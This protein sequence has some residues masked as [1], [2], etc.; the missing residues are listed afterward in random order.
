MTKPYIIYVCEGN[1]VRSPAAKIITE[2][3]AAKQGLEVVIDSMGVSAGNTSYINPDMDNAL[4]WLGFAKKNHITKPMTRQLLENADYI[5]CMERY[6]VKE[7]LKT[8]PEKQGR[9]YTLP[10]FVGYD[11]EIKILF[12]R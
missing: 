1:Q 4:V 2:E 5:F 12:L 11:K 9:V 8:I 10:E 3:L 6:Q 7:V